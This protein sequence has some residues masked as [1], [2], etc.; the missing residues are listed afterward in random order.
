M[1][2]LPAEIASMIPTGELLNICAKIEEVHF[3]ILAI[4]PLEIPQEVN[5]LF[6]ETDVLLAHKDSAIACPNV[7]VST[8]CGI[9]RGSLL[10]QFELDFYQH[11]IVAIVLKDMAQKYLL[12]KQTDVLWCIKPTEITLQAQSE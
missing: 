7:F 11:R 3:N 12:D 4:S 10:W 2:I 5:L 9:T 6:K 1:N 8:V